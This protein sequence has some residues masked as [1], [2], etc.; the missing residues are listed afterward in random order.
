MG[1]NISKFDF[2]TAKSESGKSF[3]EIAD[4]LGLTNVYT[5]QLFMNQ[6][7]RVNIEIQ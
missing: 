5:V 3:D 7:C 4:A 1:Y 6:V 2:R